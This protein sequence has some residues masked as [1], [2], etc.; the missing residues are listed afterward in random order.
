MVERRPRVDP[1]RL[2]AYEVLRAVRVEDAYTNLA[3]PAVLRSHALVDGATE[4]ERHERLAG[5]PDD[6][7]QDAAGHGRPLQRHDPDQ[8]PRRAA[9]VR[10]ARVGEG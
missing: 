8:E 2:A 3:L 5:H 10:L 6:A 4:Q 7:E 9:Q 1:A